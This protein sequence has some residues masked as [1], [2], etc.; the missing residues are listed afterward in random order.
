[1]RT[2]LAVILPVVVSL[3]GLAHAD[4]TRKCR[5]NDILKGQYVL[6]ASGFTRPVNG[7]PGTPWVPKALVEVI[8]FNGDGTLTTPMVTIANSLGDTGTTVDP[9][10][11]GA[12]GQYSIND[13]CTGTV[14]FLD[15]NR[16]TYRIIIDPPSGDT[17]WLIQTNP[18]NNVIQGTAKRVW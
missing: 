15:P 5:D 8:H 4:P 18:P 17:I 9:P 14:R 16:V 1:M 7:G 3:P 6:T 13:D 11:G 12:P 2:S 10:E